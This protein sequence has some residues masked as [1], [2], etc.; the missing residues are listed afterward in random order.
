MA[1]THEQVMDALAGVIDPEVGEDIVAI[2]LIY[3]VAIDTA[4]ITV[5][6]TM[7]SAACPMGDLILEEVRYALAEIAP[8]GTA[9]DVKLVWEP[10]WTPGRMTPALRQHFGWSE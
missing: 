3:D 10:A 5:T 8:D 4:A 2:G 6:M 9:I 1:I 7:T